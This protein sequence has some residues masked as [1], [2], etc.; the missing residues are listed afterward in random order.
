M[1]LDFSLQMQQV[2]KLLMTPQLK[3]A[4]KILQMPALELHEYIQQKIEE[5]PVLEVAD[6]EVKTDYEISKETQSENKDLIDWQE[7]F[8]DLK[9]YDEIS[10]GKE[11]I[12]KDSFETYTSNDITF[13]EYFEQQLGMLGLTK[14]EEKIGEY[15]VGSLD[16]TGYL[17]TTSTEDI[18]A[19]LGVEVEMIEKVL[20]TIQNLEPGVGARDLKECLL[21][22]VRHK[23]DAPE[24]TITII[25]NY[26]E[27]VAGMKLPKLSETLEIPIL[28]VQAIIDYIKKLNPL[29]GLAFASNIDN[30][31]IQPD[32]T[33]LEIEDEYI[34]MVNDSTIPRLQI[35]NYYKS[36]LNK[37]GEPEQQYIKDNLNNAY[38]LMR[39]IDQRKKTLQLVV[40]YIVEHQKDFFKEGVKQLKPL[41]LRDVAESL[42]IHES[43]VS[44]ATNGK[45]AETPRGIFELKYFFSGSLESGAGM[46]VATLGIKQ[47]I[48][49]MIEKEDRAKPFSDQHIADILQKE[50]IS[51]S[52]RTVAKY[53]DEGNIPSSSKRKR[54]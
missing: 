43:T 40:E 7:Y 28:E 18:A 29:P 10:F 13:L 1:K 35:N 11:V 24:H 53:R 42:E 25:E 23:G 38:Y 4:I 30:R 9:H 8:N 50:G 54:Y 26:L 46:E 51:I 32:V 41:R 47:R 16:E 34:V 2:Q 17:T 45:Y 37:G 33:I 3:Q 12:E 52:R 14:A 19:V 48:Y 5:N 15:I 6:E 39:A 20:K 49:E 44:R 31:Y 36:L 27:L 22:Q 21:L